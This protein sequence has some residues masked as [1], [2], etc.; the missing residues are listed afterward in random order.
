MWVGPFHG[1]YLRS[2]EKIVRAFSE[3]VSSLS[4]ETGTI[5]TEIIPHGTKQCDTISFF[6]RARNY[7][8]GQKRVFNMCYHISWVKN[9]VWQMS[10]ICIMERRDKDARDNVYANYTYS[11]YAAIKEPVTEQRLMFHEKGTGNII[12][13]IPEQIIRA[14]GRGHECSVFIDYGKFVLSVSLHD[15]IEQTRGVLLQC[16]S[17]YAVNPKYVKSITRFRITLSDGTVVPVPEKKYTEIK[18]KLM[19]LTIGS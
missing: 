18:R 8:G 11:S 3:G 10:V 6:T 16:H 1:Q 19:H 14:E 13:L 12:W 17:G 2:K 15:F 7:P 4:E 9:N 5:Y